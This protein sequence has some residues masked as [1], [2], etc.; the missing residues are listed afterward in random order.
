MKKG[1]QE[2][3][4]GLVNHVIDIVS[5]DAKRANLIAVVC[6]NIMTKLLFLF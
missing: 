5:L 1:C 6:C 3:L 2:N 4:A